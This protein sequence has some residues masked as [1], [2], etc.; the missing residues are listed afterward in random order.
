M[1]IAFVTPFLSGQGGTETVLL[2]V[3]NYLAQNMT[4]HQYELV[5]TE[6]SQH[7][8]WLKRL[9]RRIEIT[10]NPT[11]NPITVRLFERHYFSTTP[12]ELIISLGSRPIFVA[13]QVRDHLKR[14]YKIVSWI[15]ST[16][17][18]VRW[19]DPDSLQHADAHLAISSG[20]ADQMKDYGIAADRIYT[21]YNPVTPCEA[22][23][24][25]SQPGET[26]RFIFVG[27]IQYRGQKDLKALL[28]GLQNLRGDWT[29]DFYGAGNGL[30][31]C[32]DFIKRHPQLKPRVRWHGWITDPWAE[33]QTA[34]ALLLSSKFEGLPMVLLEAMSHGI[35][36]VSSDCPTGPA[37]IIQDG[38][39]GFLY[40]LGNT[41]KL[42]HALDRV[43][44]GYE[45]DDEET[46]RASIDK[47]YDQNYFTRVQEVIEHIV[48]Q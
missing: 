41:G 43:V 7:K 13:S 33:I 20:I 17:K 19:F 5:L 40:P 23:I 8:Q 46:I 27:R 47:F 4:N 37:D 29:I 18:N 10:E 15:H 42:H 44:Q 45:F 16:L 30:N 48:R 14:P 24:P 6:G 2:K 1:K 25:R 35:P 39:N 36:C 38:K 32:K 21:I 11:R 12:A 22:L 28:G 34:D 3:L 9:D 31:E 26:T